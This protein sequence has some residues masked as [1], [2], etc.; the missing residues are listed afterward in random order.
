SSQS[1]PRPAHSAHS[2]ATAAPNGELK[3]IADMPLTAR[4]EPFDSFWE[5][6]ANVEKGYHTFAQFYRHNY[7][8]SLPSNRSARILAISCGPGY[9]VDLLTKEGY[10]NVLGI[11][12]FPEKVEHAQRHNLNCIAAE[13]FPFLYGAPDT[14]D[15][16]VCEQELN[17]L[18]K[19]EMVKFLQL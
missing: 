8:R 14:F 13:A 16:I 3:A 12:S 15:A 10:T 11:D 19:D 9:L 18:T 17:H 4:I 2:R 1:V 6:P 7:L 5:G